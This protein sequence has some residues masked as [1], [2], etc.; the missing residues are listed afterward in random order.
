[1]PNAGSARGAV[2]DRRAG[3]RP[4]GLLVM[5]CERDRR[6]HQKHAVTHAG[7]K[8]TYL[9]GLV[10]QWARV[11]S[12]RF[13]LLCYQPLSTPNN[14]PIIPTLWRRHWLCGVTSPLIH[15]PFLSTGRTARGR[16][17]GGAAGHARHSPI[18]RPVR[19]NWPRAKL[20]PRFDR[21]Q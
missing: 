14:N 19:E 2:S 5:D 9:L 20:V 11:F 10:E 7:C 6:Q 17:A 13:G 1:V 16:R 12:T 8:S 4:F 3:G 15:L 21:V 18:P